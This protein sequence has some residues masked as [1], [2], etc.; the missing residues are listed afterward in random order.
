MFVTSQGSPHGRLRHALDRGHVNFALEAAA[1]LTTVLLTEALELCLL[2]AASADPRYPAAARRWLGR[3][4]DE[5]RPSLNELL[6]ATAAMAELAERPN[7]A[8]AR[9]TLEQLL[10]PCI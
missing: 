9:D 7:S 3:F 6:I 10:E 5:K 4:V 8:L 1:E 2:L